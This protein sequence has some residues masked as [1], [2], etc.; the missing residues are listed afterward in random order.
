MKPSLITL[1]KG[2]NTVLKF[3]YDFIEF[4]SSI[5][6]KIKSRVQFIVRKQTGTKPNKIDSIHQ[7]K[8]KV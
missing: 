4:K 1:E 2:R 6:R 5:K 3:G 7:N 8:S